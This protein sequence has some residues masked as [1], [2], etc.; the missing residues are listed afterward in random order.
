MEATISARLN[1]FGA[2]IIGPSNTTLADVFKVG[3]KAEQANAIDWENKENIDFN[4]VWKT[5]ILH[6][7][8][9]KELKLR[10]D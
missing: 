3:L 4:T 10:S 5:L 1:A 7:R 6:T 9:R 2:Q 8:W